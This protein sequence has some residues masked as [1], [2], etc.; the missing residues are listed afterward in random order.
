MIV[1]QNRKLVVSSFNIYISV[2]KT[3]DIAYNFKYIYT[4]A[5]SYIF[6]FKWLA[7][8]FKWMLLKINEF[9]ANIL[10]VKVSGI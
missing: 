5:N 3:D 9:S 4:H 2:L 10:N 6:I 8:Q 7:F 1:S